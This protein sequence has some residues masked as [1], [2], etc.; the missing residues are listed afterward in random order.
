MT[1]ADNGF[2]AEKFFEQRQRTVC[3]T[4]AVVSRLQYYAAGIVI[5]MRAVNV[6][7]SSFFSFSP[8]QYFVSI[9]SG[10]YWTAAQCSVQYVVIVG[11][12]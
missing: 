6:Q 2:A 3:N 9:S 11:V 10:K 5:D 8:L 1:N 4:V 12:D 7:Y